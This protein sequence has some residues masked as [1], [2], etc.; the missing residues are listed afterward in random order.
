MKIAVLTMYVKRKVAFLPFLS[1]FRCICLTP[2]GGE[3]PSRRSGCPTLAPGGFVFFPHQLDQLTLRDSKPFGFCCDGLSYY[4][5][6][7]RM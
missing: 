6:N 3:V 1:I 2:K 5:E 7:L 4:W